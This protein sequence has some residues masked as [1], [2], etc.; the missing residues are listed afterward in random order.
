MIQREAYPDSVAPGWVRARPAVDYALGWILVF[1]MATSVVNVLWQVTTRFILQDPSG[2]TDE[3]ARFLLICIGLLGGAYAV[4][5]QLHLAI[6]LLPARLRGRPASV[7]DIVIR[8]TVLLFALAV[9]VVGGGRLVYIVFTLDQT[10]AALE[11]PLA[12][13]YL[14]LPFSGVLIMYYSATFIYEQVGLLR[15]R[16]SSLH[17]SAY[18]SAR[19]YTEHIVHPP[20]DSGVASGS[21]DPPGPDLEE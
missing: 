7:L 17:G 20:P 3:L 2:F 16:T 1:L 21:F 4:G 12:W 6:D 10:S 8:C 5:K 15:G 11:I 13:V 19:A 18:T 9:L 14:V